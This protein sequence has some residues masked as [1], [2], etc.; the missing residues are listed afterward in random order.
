MPNPRYEQLKALLDQLR[1]EESTLR[2]TFTDTCR[3]MGSGDVWIG[4]A[5]RAWE[6]KMSAYDAQM[7]RLVAGA[8]GE[9]E[10]ALAA[11]PKEIGPKGR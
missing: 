9:V 1:R 5:A 2:R 4:P 3:R 8:I 10:A 6:T 7:R 11:T